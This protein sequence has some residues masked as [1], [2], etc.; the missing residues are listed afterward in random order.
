MLPHQDFWRDGWGLVVDGVRFTRARIIDDAVGIGE[1]GYTEV[2]AEATAA[3]G[4]AAGSAAAKKLVDPESPLKDPSNDG[5]PLFD[6]NDSDDDE[7]VE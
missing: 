7:L 5:K 1:G 6:N 4:G 3:T 2:S